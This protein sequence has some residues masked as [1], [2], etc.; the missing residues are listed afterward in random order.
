MVGVVAVDG[1]G[2]FNH[3]IWKLWIL[4][5]GQDVPPMAEILS[6]VPLQEI[7]RGTPFDV[8]GRVIDPD[9]IF[10]ECSSTSQE[11][12]EDNS[13]WD[14][15]G[16]G[17]VYWSLN[18]GI[19]F[20]GIGASGVRI[21][22]EGRYNL[23]ML[24]TDGQFADLKSVQFLVVHPDNL[25]QPSIIYPAQTL[26]VQPDQ[27]VYFEGTVRSGSFVNNSFTWK[28]KKAG[29]GGYTE[30]IRQNKLGYYSFKEAGRYEVTCS[31][32]NPRNESLTRES[33]VRE[34]WV[35]NVPVVTGNTTIES[36]AELPTGLFQDAN[37]DG[38]KF[39]RIRL[40]DR[41]QNLKLQLSYEGTAKLTLY[42]S[43]KEPV[44]TRTFSGQSSI[45]LRGLQA[46]DYY[47]QFEPS[48]TKR[49]AGVTFGMSVDVTNAGLYFPDV[50]HNSTF[51]TS[52]GLVNPYSQELV[53]ELYAY[54]S[55]GGLLDQVPLRI[56]GKGRY[57]SAI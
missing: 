54:D 12:L 28:I 39:Y 48:S 56:G 44:E 57:N 23:S 53:L 30:S 14:K 45:Q 10:D 1:D 5:V 37:V 50:E 41:G 36:A 29:A 34:I 55:N 22:R 51:D 32:V 20:E 16:E 9:T 18:N 31:A 3:K 25:A 42:N 26:R 35:E 13:Y 17:Q 15:D 43:S 7:P 33:D 19:A 11:Y 4:E 46:G 24:A 2:G 52:V 8:C 21:N 38:P 6:P 47:I 40:L 49:A 27:P